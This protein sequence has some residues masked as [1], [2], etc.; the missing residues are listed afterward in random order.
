M[1]AAD[2]YLNSPPMLSFLSQGN[3][4]SQVNE[5]KDGF[6]ITYKL[7]SGTIV[8]EENI[9]NFQQEIH[10]KYGVKDSSWI[11]VKE[12]DAMSFSFTFTYRRNIYSI[13]FNEANDDKLDVFNCE[14]IQYQDDQW[15]YISLFDPICRDIAYDIRPQILT[16]LE[17]LPET[18]LKCLLGKVDIRI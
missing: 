8:T 3:K 7:R 12:N 18:R 16:Y 1:N 9:T 17:T 13:M 14:V 5:T 10:K 6:K 15:T 2:M 11:V 4:V